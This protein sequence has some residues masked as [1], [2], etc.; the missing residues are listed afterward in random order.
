MKRK[1]WM[2]AIVILV[3]LIP[4]TVLAGQHT[5]AQE[6]TTDMIPITIS[7]GESEFEAELINNAAVQALL[8]QMPVTVTMNELNGNEKYYYMSSPLPTDVQRV[9]NIR[10]GDLMLYGSDCLVL[11]YEDFAT[12]YRYTRLGA[13]SNPDKLKEAL[14]DGD[15]Q[16]SFS[17]GE[18]SSTGQY[19]K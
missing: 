1:I 18:T 6:E 14:G 13:V 17:R 2:V 4:T 15:V 10:T 5:K 12:S 19:N 3:L 7:V 16:V 9:G 8:E 11:F